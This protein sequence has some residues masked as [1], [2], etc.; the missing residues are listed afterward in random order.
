MTAALLNPLVTRLSPP[1]IPAVQAWGRS[2]AGGHGPLIDLS[3][4]V[5]GYPPHPDMLR[6]LGEAASSV[7]YANYGPIEG[8]I[9]LRDAYAT[10]MS[11]LYGAGIGGQNVHI[12]SGCNQAFICAAMVVAAAGETVLVSDPFYF[13][14]ETTLSMLGI[15]TGFV[16]CNAENGFVPTVQAVEK[17]LVPGVRALALVTPNNPT[18]A[19]YSPERLKAIFEVCRKRG[20]WLILDET[21]RDFL[22][23]GSGEPHDLFSEVGWEDNLIQL[24]SFSK[25]FCIPGHRLGAVTAGE[26]V[27]TEIAKIMDNLQICA[28]RAPQ[29]AV[30]RALPALSDWRSAN[31]LEIETRANALRETMIGLGGWKLEAVGAYF[32]FVRHPFENKTSVEVAEQLAKQAGILAIPGEY[33]GA[34]H[35]QFLRFA[36]ANANATTI[37]QL[38]DRMIDFSC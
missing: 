19:V 30:A 17:A 21:Y 24:Y 31:R 33:F 1:P 2:Y 3:Q 37:R 15:K 26:A 20:V 29:I 13:N 4:A 14:H 38:R 22:T 18:G 35:T 23:D 11:E 7:A 16:P 10:H 36:F 34:G 6:W 8:E 5:P 27:V 9:I 32:A 28:P 12:T 25:S